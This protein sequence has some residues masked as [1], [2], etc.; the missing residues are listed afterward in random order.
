MSEKE[1]GEWRL[2]SNEVAVLT[3]WCEH[4]GC[5]R[6][7]AWR[8]GEVEV[9]AVK[10]KGEAVIGVMVDRCWLVEDELRSIRL[11]STG[12]LAPRVLLRAGGGSEG[13]QGQGG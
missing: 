3:K 1:S 5:R 11:D 10:A 9:K 2:M 6:R 13:H 8:R 4:R 12:D 7:G